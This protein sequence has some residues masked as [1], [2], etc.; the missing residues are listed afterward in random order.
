MEQN[1]LISPIITASAAFTGAVIA[2]VISH[3]FS[4]RRELKKERKTIYQNY[5]API[6]PELFLYIDSMTHFYGGNKK[7]NV[8]EE[9]F[10]THII[11]H[12]SKN[13]RYASP[14]VLSLFN[15]VNKYKYMDDLSGFNKEIQELEL[16]LGVL[17]EYYHLAK[18]S[19]ILEKKELGQILS[20]RVNYL[21]WLCV[22]NYCQWPKKS[23]CITAYK[24]LLDDTKYNEDLLKTIRNLTNA[25]KWTDAL[26]YFV[27]L[28]KSEK[29]SLE[30]KEV[31][32]ERFKD[33]KH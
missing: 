9:E 29:E 15:S 32:F 24:W 12:I 33:M 5:F 2:Q 23:V 11:D 16:L 30:L 1:T 7:V 22:L 14:R 3:W 26:N 13:L 10:K 27:K 20:Y 19:K 17:D 8:N 21:F 28:T 6:V 4:V 18:E 25:E 31:I